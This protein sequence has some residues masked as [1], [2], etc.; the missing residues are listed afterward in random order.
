MPIPK[1]KKNPLNLK[2]KIDNFACYTVAF[3]KTT[4]FCT[5]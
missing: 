3:E 5:I 1:K 2:V 4:F